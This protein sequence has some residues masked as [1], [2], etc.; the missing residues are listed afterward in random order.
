VRD[1][2]AESNHLIVA[3]ATRWQVVLRDGDVSSGVEML[4]SAARAGIDYVVSGEFLT[5]PEG[6]LL[7]ARLTDVD[8]GV[9]LSPHRADR[10]D[11][12]ALL[13][14]SSRL[15]LMVKRGLGVPHTENVSGFSA[16][17]AVRN[18]AAYEVYLS[19]IGYFLAFDYRAAERAFRAALDL[20]PDYH[21]ARYRLA[22]VQAAAGDTA[23]G[24]ATLDGIP[25]DAPLSRRERAYVDGA[26]AMFTRDTTRAKAIYEALLA[27]LPFDV[28][29]RWLLALAYDLAFEDEAAIA[30]LRRLVEQEPQNDRYWSY[31][32]ETYLRLGDVANARAALDTYLGL[33]PRDPFGFSILGE[34]ELIGGDVPAATTRFAHALELEPG[35]VRARLGFARANVLGDRWDEADRLFGE[36]I[37]DA[38][39][40]AGDRIDAAFDR[41]ALAR[42]QGRFADAVQPLEALEPLIRQEEIR[43]ALSLSERALAVAELGRF[44]DAERLITLAVARSPAAPTRYLF[45][46]GAVAALRGDAAAIASAAAALRALAIPEDGPQDAVLVKEARARAATCLDGLAALA[47]GDTRAAVLALERAVSM[48]GYP[49]ALYA[50]GLAQARLAD[51]DALR[52]LTDVRAA[53]AQRAPGELRLD[54][55]LDRSRAIL[56]EAEILEALGRMPEAAARARAFLSR[57]RAPADDDER[58]RAE[59]LARDAETSERDASQAR[60]TSGSRA[61]DRTVAAVAVEIP[62]EEARRGTGATHGR[63][64]EGQLERDHQT[65]VRLVRQ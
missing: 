34:L 2:L 42:A 32:G 48:A 63:G 18:M 17:F 56:L 61:V 5:T 16:D 55:E 51:G 54:L 11:A 58:R 21:M 33:H 15:A 41:S 13:A 22:H 44:E 27:E 23:A 28:E 30:N 50:V 39:A 7:T 57:W 6:L 10:L 35:F 45:A 65:Q 46:R 1:D 52:A 37:V 43:E 38:G 26:R 14:E 36:L 31:L 12:A 24:I 20:A 53:L 49:Y 64:R 3:S 60:R 29:A 62:V 40:P 8:A 4:R 25:A 47:S 19:G 59:A 9:D